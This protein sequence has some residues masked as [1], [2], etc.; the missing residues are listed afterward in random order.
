MLLLKRTA[1]V[2]LSWRLLMTRIRLALMLYF[3]F[4]AHK[5]ACTPCRR[6]SWSLWR[7]GRGLASAGDIS[8]RGFS[9]WRSALWCSFL[10]WSLPVLL[11][12]WLQSVQYDLQYDFAWVAGEAD[13]SV[14]LVVLQVAFLNGVMPKDWV[15]RVC[16]S[17][18]CQILLQI[19]VRVVITSSPPAWTS[20]S[21]T[22]STLADFHFFNDCTLSLIVSVLSPVNHERLHQGW[23]IV[24][25]SQ[26]LCEWWGGRPVCVPGDSS[27]LM[28]LRWSCDCTAQSSR[29]SIGSVYLALL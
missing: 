20:S 2:I 22:L 28:D 12:L 16:H 7:H 18:V 9:G 14:V 13:L 19:V 29:L 1:V 11:R 3:F 21:G 4:V 10:L 25:H 24:R 23:M 26:L 15:H 5:A 8:Y 6:P 27:V 17:S